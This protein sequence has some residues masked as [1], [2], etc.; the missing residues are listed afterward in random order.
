MSA[1][2]RDA[3]QSHPRGSTDNWPPCGAD[4]DF[5]ADRL[6]AAACRFGGRAKPHDAVR[7]WRRRAAES[8]SGHSRLASSA[9]RNTASRSWLLAVIFAACIGGGQAAAGALVVVHEHRCRQPRV[10]SGAAGDLMA[11]NQ[12]SPFGDDRRRILGE[13]RKELPDMIE[14]QRRRRNRKA[15]PIGARWCRHDAPGFGQVLQGDIGGF[16]AAQQSSDGGNRCGMLWML[17]LN[18]PQQ[19]VRIDEDAHCPRGSS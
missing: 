15:E 2:S 17:C 10:K 7:R 1:A 12:A 5:A 3:P 14:R 19:H 18:P 6:G 13:Q 11:F 8:H 9:A 4:A 16:T